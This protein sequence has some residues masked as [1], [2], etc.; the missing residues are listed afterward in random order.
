MIRIDFIGAP[1]SGKTT[2]INELL[3]ISTI[4]NASNLSQAR[5]DVL[6]NYFSIDYTSI[7]QRLKSIVIN[8]LLSKNHSAY[9]KRK[10]NLFFGEAMEPYNDIL[11]KIL[12][13]L[14]KTEN[15]FGYL[16]FK[17]IGW[18]I[19]ILEDTLLVSKYANS[20]IVLCDE[21]LSSKLLQP[22]FGLSHKDITN[23]LRD[24]LMPSA[25]VHVRCKEELLNKRLLGRK[26]LTLQHSGMGCDYKEA[27]NESIKTYNIVASELM[28]LEIP[29]LII[30]SEDDI[31]VNLVKIKKFINQLK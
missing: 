5:I 26:K 29:C 13:N 27:I 7:S 23:K 28:K 24:S 18:F 17:R 2:L 10:L 8:R 21:S 1:G 31:D 20:K 6:S 12:D 11:T 3:A 9:S 19:Q 22:D 30:N 16:K 15:D 25:F 4:K 14:T